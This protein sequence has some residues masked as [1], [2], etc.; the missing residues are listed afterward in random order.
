MEC[1]KHLNLNRQHPGSYDGTGWHGQG[2][3]HDIASINP[4][5]NTTLAS[6][7]MANEQDI[8][9]VMT[10]SHDTFL[11]WRNV[12]APQRAQ[13]VKAIGQ[14]L[15]EQKDMLGTLVSMEMGKSKQEGDG[16]IQEMID[17]ADYAVGLSRMFG[18]HTL[19]SEREA[20]RLFEQW[21]PLGVVAV[22]TAFNF[23]VAVWAW[24]AFIAAV[25]G[26]TVIWKP[27]GKTPLCA[28]A[29]HALCQ[30]VMTEQKCP[31]VFSLIISD[32]V[33]RINQLID[34]KRIPLVSFTGSTAVG[35]Q[36]N[37]RVASRLGR[38]ILELSGNN[39]SI[40]DHR[41]NLDIAI[42]AIVFAAVGTAGQRCTST[43]RLLVEKSMYEEVRARLLAAYA[44]ITI[45]DPLDERN[46]LGPLVDG[47]AV[48]QYLAAIEAVRAEGGKVL[49]GG[50]KIEGPGFF[51]APT[52][53]EIALDASIVQAET[54]GP[55][56]YM[57]AYDRLEDAIAMQ[58]AVSLGL[59]SSL[60]TESLRA[61]EQFLSAKGSDCG[62]AN[63]NTS[64]SGAEIGGAFGGEKDTG[65]GREA[66]SDAWKSYM[67]RQT[68]TINGGTTLPLAQGVKFE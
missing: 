6:V 27:S 7:V 67:R 22:I 56:L 3:G 28:I 13:L 1:L 46:L 34:D 38:T 60:F 66:G 14:R 32:N 54:F 16:E 44:T 33:D 39:A 18:G 68:V 40:V 49:Y 65:G 2:D 8:K 36:V 20:H 35:R 58:N 45:G 31:G 61:S 43:R 19:H 9:Q 62:I 5:N 59:S 63:I 50:K 55:I 29:I 48:A 17:M 25:C 42:P 47:A 51:V 53:V 30:E 23:P 52:L 21:H 15:V 24:N 12:P 4:S 10:T 26:D 37:T 64:T 57:S 41:A 11:C